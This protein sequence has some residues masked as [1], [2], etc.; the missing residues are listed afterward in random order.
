MHIVRRSRESLHT[1]P[2]WDALAFAW[3]V[4]D[5]RRPPPFWFVKGL[6]VEPLCNKLKRLGST[7]LFVASKARFPMRL[8]P[9]PSLQSKAGVRSQNVKLCHPA[10][11]DLSPS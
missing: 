1:S 4:A 2:A 7:C 11:K 3:S 6:S 10:A 5:V 8:L 9:Q